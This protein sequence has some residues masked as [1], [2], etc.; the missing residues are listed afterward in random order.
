VS[1]TVTWDSPFYLYNNINLDSIEVDKPE[2]YRELSGY[3]AELLAHKIA[4]YWIKEERLLYYRPNKDMRKAYDYYAEDQIPNAIQQWQT[5]YN[6]GTQT[7]A[8]LAAYN[9]AVSYEVIDSL[10]LANEWINKS[11]ALKPNPDSKLY[12]SILA[13]RLS[14]SY[15]LNSQLKQTKNKN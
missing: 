10:S 13:Q 8:S 7:L 6:N 1:D 4:P 11:V 9:I 2:M 5:V 12:Q 14:D 3:V 15:I